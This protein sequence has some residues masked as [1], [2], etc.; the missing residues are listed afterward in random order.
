MPGM[1]AK[2]EYDCR[3]DA[4]LR[5]SGVN[6]SFVRRCEEPVRGYRLNIGRAIATKA[7]TPARLA[8]LNFKIPEHMTAFQP[9]PRNKGSAIE[10]PKPVPQEPLPP[11][12]KIK[13]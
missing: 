12:K 9:I 1:A 13:D 8:Y 3:T 2:I 6:L 5:N 11:P 4:E 10:Q 7:I